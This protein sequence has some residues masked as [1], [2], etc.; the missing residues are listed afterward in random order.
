MLAHHEPMTARH[1]AQ[2]RPPSLRLK[3]RRHQIA[4]LTNRLVNGGGYDA[5]V[6][7][8]AGQKVM[9][10]SAIRIARLARVPH[11]LSL[12]NATETVRFV[13]FLRRSLR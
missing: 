2:P 5:N 1:L 10:H 11:P 3:I 9:E 4:K 7:L 8:I 13:E 12:G 6:R